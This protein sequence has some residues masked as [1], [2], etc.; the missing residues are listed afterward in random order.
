MLQT[1]T[2][3]SNEKN[4][5]R[6]YKKWYSPHLQRDME[7]LVFGFAG[8]PVIFFPT[9]TARFY[10]Y[11]DWKVIEALQPKIDSGELQI[12]CIDSADKQSFYNKSITPAER[13]L[14]HNLFER[15]ILQE[16]FAFIKT[17]NLHP[18]IISAGCS[19][20]A[21]HA[22]NIAFRYP[23]LFHK[24]V[25]MSGRYDITIQLPYFEDLFEG[26]RDNHILYHMPTQYLPLIQSENLINQLRKLEIII[27]IGNED[28]FLQNNQL[29]HTQLEN[30]QIQHEFHIWKGE[31]HKAQYWSEMVQIYF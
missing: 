1:S 19:L 28:A 17:I 12:F 10:D 18:E 2:V 29:L 25:G 8:K 7:M 4:A 11:E 16:V 13:I 22:V 27:A 5:R 6:H 31:A 3:I 30:K 9:R 14:K 23:Q 21:Y 26:Y 15:Y 24:V 20:G